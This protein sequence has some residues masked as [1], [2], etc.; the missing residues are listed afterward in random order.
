MTDASATAA[1]PPRAG[2]IRSLAALV[3]AQVAAL[4]TW[5]S[6]AAVTPALALDHGLAPADLAGL[7]SATQGG[8]VVGAVILAATGLADRVDPRRLFAACALG[9]AFANLTLL[10]SPPDGVLAAASR[11]LVGAAL[12]GVYPVGLKIAVGWSVAKRGLVTSL[13]VGAP[14]LGSATPHAAT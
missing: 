11:A 7:T 13:L 9:A 14:T 4:S 1:A 5:F 3:A 10:I 8:F 2:Q 6:A 12:A